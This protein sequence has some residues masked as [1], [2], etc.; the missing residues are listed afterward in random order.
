MGRRKSQ[1]ERK[2]GNS[3]DADSSMGVCNEVKRKFFITCSSVRRAQQTANFTLQ[4]PLFLP[5]PCKVSYMGFSR[6][7]VRVVLLFWFC[8]AFGA[9]IIR[10]VAV[11][12]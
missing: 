1:S 10:N 7:E 12:G 11:G 4:G 9:T 8:L 6:A 5:L 2:R 3:W